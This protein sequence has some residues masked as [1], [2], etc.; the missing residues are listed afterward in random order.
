VAH[1]SV[2]ERFQRELGHRRVEDEGFRGVVEDPGFVGNAVP[3]VEHDAQ[4]LALGEGVPDPD[5]QLRVVGEDGATADHD[6]V[7]GVADQM[8]VGPRGC[9]RDPARGVVGGRDASVQRG[10]VLPRDVRTAISDGVQPWPQRSALGRVR[11]D[12][13]HD[14]DAG[15]AQPL[16]TS[17][18]LG[19]RIV[20]GVDDLGDAGFDER[21]RARAGAADVRAGLERDDRRTAARRFAGVAQCRDLGMRTTGRG[22]CTLAGEM[23]LRVQDHRTDGRVRAGPAANRLGQSQ[24]AVHRRLLG[25]ADLH[26]PF[27][28]PRACARSAAMAWPGSAAP[29]TADP[30]TNTSAPASAA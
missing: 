29:N 1:S 3:T 11:F 25:L 30:A 27:I 10:G 4:R 6:R 23:A 5:G 8:D 9:R 12:I 22:G 15:P 26:Q 16:G 14:L 19:V 17:A 13:G 2:V 18:G 24:R 21:V 20:D 7:D 28:A